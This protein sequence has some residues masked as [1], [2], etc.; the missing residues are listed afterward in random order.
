MTLIQTD[1]TQ[2]QYLRCDRDYDCPRGRFCWEGDKSCRKDEI[3]ALKENCRRHRDC[4]GELCCDNKQ[5]CNPI[6]N[7]DAKFTCD[8]NYDCL[9]PGLKCCKLTKQ[10][11]L[12]NTTELACAKDSDCGIGQKCCGDG[13]DVCC[14]QG[15]VLAVRSNKA[16]RLM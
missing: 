4:P 2:G 1:Y 3:K 10:C 8:Y 6:A 5:C 11:C 7:A 13:V 14:D 9:M 16:A 12:K 15:R